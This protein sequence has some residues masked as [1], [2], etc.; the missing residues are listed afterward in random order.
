KR[1]K[2]S[3]KLK[4]LASFRGVLKPRPLGVVVYLKYFRKDNYNEKYECNN[5][6]LFEPAGRTGKCNME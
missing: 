3:N 2:K 4:V 1:R 6:G 5:T